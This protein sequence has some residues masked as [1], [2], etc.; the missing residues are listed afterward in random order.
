MELQQGFLLSYLKYGDQNAI[1]HLYTRDQGYKSYFLK[2]VYNPKSKIKAYLSPLN[3]VKFS[4]NASSRAGS[5]EQIF[6]LDIEQF[7][8]FQG[9]KSGSIVFF[10]ADFLNQTLRQENES[11]AIYNEIH[12]FLKSLENKNFNSHLIFLLQLLKIQGLSPLESEPLFLNPES[13]RFDVKES[14][15]LFNQEIS[16]LWKAILRD[17]YPYEKSV[18]NNLRRQFLDSLLVYYHY[19]Y[20]N[21]RKPQSLDIVQQIFE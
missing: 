1:L 14:H 17:A 2:G 11:Q 3:E 9:V 21:F 10:I 20:A 15:H 18:P 4:I 12:N 7:K 8:E 5:L 13:G 6:K 16:S 19:H